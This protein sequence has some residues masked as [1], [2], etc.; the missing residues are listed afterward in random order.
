MLR[1]V[2]ESNSLCEIVNGVL[3]AGLGIC[4]LWLLWG[5]FTYQIGVQ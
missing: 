3:Q 5:V 4:L 1:I 2:Q